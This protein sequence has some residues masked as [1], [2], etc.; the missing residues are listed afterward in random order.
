MGQ[1]TRVV[2]CAVFK[3]ALRHLMLRRRYPYMRVTS[4]PAVLHLR[5]RDL[6]RRLRR[7]CAAARA[8]GER[9]I[10][11]YGEC[12]PGISEFCRDQ[13]VL[14][15]PGD[16]CYEMLLGSER[17]KRLVDEAAGTYFVERN[18]ILNFQEVCLRPLELDDEEMR[19]SCFEHY[20]RLLYVRQPD[21]P[22]IAPRAGELAWFLGLSLE[23]HDADYSYLERELV[24][25]V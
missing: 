12:F 20:K 6:E 18:L 8:R 21:D 14:K 7:E 25:L 16:Y 3:P 19:K 10:C 1:V 22:E 13:G 15:V 17:F 2:A 24:R 23:I 9:T 4:L 11:L 5:P